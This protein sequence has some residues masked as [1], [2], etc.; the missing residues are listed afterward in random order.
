MRNIPAVSDYAH[1][2]E[3]ASMVWYEENRYDMEH[4]AED[5]DYEY[6]YGDRDE[7]PELSEAEE[8][9][10]LGYFYGYEVGSDEDII[11]EVRSRDT[12]GVF[13]SEFRRG[14]DEG[15]SDYC[16]KTYG[17]SGDG[18]TPPLCNIH[19]PEVE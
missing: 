13:L 6:Y 19:V 16:R 18:L 1:Y 3:E 17:E 5:D 14:Y 10:D 7:G 15:V 12:D 9:F 11:E 2:G 8:A 4:P